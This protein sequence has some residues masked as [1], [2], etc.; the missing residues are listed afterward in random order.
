MRESSSFP[1]SGRD[2]PQPF[3]LHVYRPVGFFLEPCCHPSRSDSN[4][5]ANGQGQHPSWPELSMDRPISIV[6]LAKKIDI[7]FS[8]S[9]PGKVDMFGE[10]FRFADQRAP[11][12]ALYF[13][14]P[15]CR[16]SRHPP[17]VCDATYIVSYRLNCSPL[18]RRCWFVS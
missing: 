3:S 17:F 9:C 16:E 7:Q 4:L 6:E 12:S 2:S 13:L 8:S 14:A 10:G 5:Y 11:T 18:S 15:L 1:R